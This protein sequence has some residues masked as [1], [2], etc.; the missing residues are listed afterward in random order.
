MLWAKFDQKRPDAGASIELFIAKQ[1]YDRQQG[2]ILDLLKR[3]VFD[4]IKVIEEARLVELEMNK[5][6]SRE[7]MIIVKRG[8]QH[9]VENGS[10]R[11]EGLEYL[12]EKRT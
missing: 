10:A 9:F 7:L 12:I 3:E 4:Y 5:E 2:V 1:E 8:N 6:V 11:L